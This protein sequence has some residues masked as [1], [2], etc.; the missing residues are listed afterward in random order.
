MART[1]PFFR[2]SAPYHVPHS[3]Y[4]LSSPSTLE[5]RA[6]P[7][8]VLLIHKGSQSP[9]AGERLAQVKI[10]LGHDRARETTAFEFHLLYFI[11]NLDASK[12]QATGTNR[13]GA[14]KAAAV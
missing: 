8:S 13:R 7:H 11:S 9:H 6:A 10:R 2:F 12:F 4:D 3:K 1:L 5:P 14:R